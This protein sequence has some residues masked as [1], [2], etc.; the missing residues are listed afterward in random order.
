MLY[1]NFLYNFYIGVIFVYLLLT[2]FIGLVSEQSLAY[3]IKGNFWVTGYSLF[4]SLHVSNFFFFLVCL[5]TIIFYHMDICFFLRNIF[6][7]MLYTLKFHTRRYLPIELMLRVWKLTLW[8]TVLVAER[9][10]DTN[11]RACGHSQYSYFLQVAPAAVSRP[12]HVRF[13]NMSAVHLNWISLCNCPVSSLS[14]TVH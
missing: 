6:W 14:R 11:G 10:S 13:L 4:C 8:N 9:K 5:D 3:K 7:N 12:A 2:W 1:L